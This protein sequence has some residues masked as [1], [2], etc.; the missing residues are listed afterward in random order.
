M[1]TGI[2]V[3]FCMLACVVSLVGSTAARCEV[4][5]NHHS[6]GT[7]SNT[8]GNLTVEC[9]HPDAGSLMVLHSVGTA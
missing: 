4:T 5:Y 8:V 6:P 2:C 3:V 7:A 9:S 1:H